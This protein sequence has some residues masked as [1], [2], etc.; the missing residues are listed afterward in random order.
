VLK[1]N[2]HHLRPIYYDYR[3]SERLYILEEHE[4]DDVF[5]KQKRRYIN[6]SLTTERRAHQQMSCQLERISNIVID[7]KLLEISFNAGFL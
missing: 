3:F 6:R 5:P 4:L 2:Q 7:S 1:H